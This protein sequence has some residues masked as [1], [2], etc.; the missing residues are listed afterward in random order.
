M[1]A[2]FPEPGER[3]PLLAERRN[4]KMARSA[5]AYVRGSTAK[6]YDW[7]A[8]ASGRIPAGPDIWICGDCHLG[9]LGP[10]GSAKGKTDIQIRDLDQTV[11]GKPA[12]DLIRLGLSLATVA[13]GSDLPGVTTA[14]MIEQIIEGYAAALADKPD[15][16]PSG[17]KPDAVRLAMRK[18]VG[19]TWKHL[20]QDRIKNVK[21][22]IPLG[23][24]F[25]PLSADEMAEAREIV[26]QDQV[27]RLVTALYCREDDVRID[28]LD[29]AYWVKGCSSLGGTRI[30][31]LVGIGD[32]SH[33]DGGLGL[34]DVKEA[35]R[36]AAPHVPRAKMPRD[37]AERVVEGA[38]H[39]S[40]YLGNRMC[41]TRFLDRP[42]FIRELLPQDI[43][44]DIEHFSSDQAVEA[45]RFLAAVVG[46]AHA[47]QMDG[48]T[49]K[50]WRAELLRSRSKTLEAP[51]WLWSSIV[52]L[53]TSHEAAY[54]EHCR[55]YAFGSE[56][57]R[58]R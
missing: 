52:E 16:A 1:A 22:T 5:H 20:A 27:R 4:L 37:Q 32:Q 56:A 18:A 45:A 17:A 24:R 21:P 9:N 34:F 11:I 26:T 41:A 55:R 33:D 36:S 30:A 44:L 58:S 8:E 53:I 50:D 47:R 10:V 12:H 23:K 29:A 19:R 7:L 39:L 25:W 31:L 38:R 43:T 49:R 40:P 48:A 13:S 54:L 3:Q 42:V 6:F 14:R 15:N 46:R 28:L 35:V 51:S 57:R 2:R